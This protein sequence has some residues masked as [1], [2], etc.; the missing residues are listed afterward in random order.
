MIGSGLF[1]V[2]FAHAHRPNF[3]AP[4]GSDVSG[5]RALYLLINFSYLQDALIKNNQ[6]YISIGGATWPR[7]RRMTN[8]NYEKSRHLNPPKIIKN[9]S[10]DFFPISVKCPAPLALYKNPDSLSFGIIM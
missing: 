6:L 9:L 3:M 1:H 5:A 4:T 8:I 7:E 2:V 10:H